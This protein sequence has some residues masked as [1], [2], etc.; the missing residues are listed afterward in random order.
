MAEASVFVM[1][2]EKSIY[3]SQTDAMQNHL[4]VG[5]GSDV[6]IAE[7]ALAVAKATDYKGGIIFDSSKPDGSPQK[8][9][10]SN[11]LNKLGWSPKV[12]LAEGLSQAYSEMLERLS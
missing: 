10:D 1:E 4:N 2:L 8:W 3:D 12:G 11:K 9:M 6:T 5:Y 7:L